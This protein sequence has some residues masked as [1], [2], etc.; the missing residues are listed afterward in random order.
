[1]TDVPPTSLGA[2]T[3]CPLSGP[4]LLELLGLS[5]E[6]HRVDPAS[7]FVVA[8][9]TGVAELGDFVES[10]LECARD[11][12]ND[13]LRDVGRFKGVTEREPNCTPSNARRSVRNGNDLRS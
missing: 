11:R 8:T 1:M 12:S 7:G 4:R 13:C 2:G 5:T 6:I 3:R 10:G 9:S